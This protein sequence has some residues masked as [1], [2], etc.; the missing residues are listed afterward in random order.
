MWL[1]F[2]KFGKGLKLTVVLGLLEYFCFPLQSYLQISSWLE[3][4]TEA[5]FV[6]NQTY[7][8]LNEDYLLQKKV[9]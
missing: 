8:T 3:I 4:E 9:I 2:L 7:G 6:S 1:F 5:I